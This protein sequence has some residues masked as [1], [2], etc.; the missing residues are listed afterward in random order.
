MNLD[1]VELSEEQMDAIIMA[2]QTQSR[3]YWRSGAGKR[4]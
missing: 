2:L 3:Y 4:L 1:N